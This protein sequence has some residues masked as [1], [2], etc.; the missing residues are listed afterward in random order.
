MLKQI[1]LPAI[2]ATVVSLTGVTMADG[3]LWTRCYEEAQ[4]KA[5][6]EGKSILMEFTGSDW[7]PPCK[8]LTKNVFK[9]EA[10]T[11]EAP[12]SFVLLLLD[13]PRDKSKQTKEEIAQNEKLK[14][15]YSISGYPTILLTDDQGRPFAKKVGYGGTAAKAYVADL[16]KSAGIRQQ[17]DDL[18]AKAEGAEGIAKA[19]LLDQSLSLL[20][21]ELVLSSYSDTVDEIVA[22]D[23]KDAAGLKSKYGELAKVAQVKEVIAGIQRSGNLDESLAKLNKVITELDLKGEALQEAMYFKGV[24][25]Y[26]KGDKETSKT[27]LEAALKLS[28]DSKLGKQIE[29]ILGSAFK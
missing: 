21:S 16:S 24:V 22:L 19:K 10:F 20:D 17:L 5:K 15:K 26:K 14:N 18:R 23:P 13:F 12:Q 27:T 4:A 8:A 11:A 6:K 7:C 29:R 1:T 9:T 25:Q 3:D 2:L 28:A